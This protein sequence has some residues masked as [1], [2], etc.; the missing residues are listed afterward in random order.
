MATNPV[1]AI[2]PQQKPSIFL[3]V[4]PIKGE[5]KD[6]GHPGE[7]EILDVK[8]ETIQ[9]RSATASFTG[10]HTAA[11]SELSKFSVIKAVDLS[12]PALWQQCANGTTMDKLKL[13]FERADVQG[14]PTQYL[15]IEALNVIVSRIGTEIGPEGM[16]LET[17]EFHVGAVKQTYTSQKPEGGAGGKNVAQYSFVKNTPQYAV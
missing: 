16:P 4:G 3:T 5:S 12:S 14:R 1:V 9:P 17:V 6:Q 15:V 2:N 7:I 8:L 11:R 10:G 13:T